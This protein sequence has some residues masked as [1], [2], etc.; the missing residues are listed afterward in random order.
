MND[1]GIVIVN[2]LAF[3]R[4]NL[5]NGKYTRAATATVAARRVEIVFWMKVE[6]THNAEY[7][8][9]R[10]IKSRRFNSMYTI[11]VNRNH[12]QSYFPT[13]TDGPYELTNLHCCEIWII[14]VGVAVQL[15]SGL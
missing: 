4:V 1:F 13:A 2:E 5:V 12:N 11:F 7:I 15:L 3:Y 8:Q 9:Y 10:R 14:G 6:M